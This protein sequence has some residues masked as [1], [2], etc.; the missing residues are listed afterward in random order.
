M[1]DCIVLT[2]ARYAAPRTVDWYVQQVLDEDQ[3]VV[4]A[5]RAQ[6]LS[7]ERRSWDDPTIDFSEVRAVIFRTTWDYFDRWPEFSAWLETV[8]NQTKLINAAELVHW[9]LDKRYLVE[10]AAKSI[11]VVPTVLVSKDDPRSLGELLASTGWE[12][13][14]AKPAISGAGRDTFRV[15]TPV[16]SAKAERWA[17][18]VQAEDMLLQPFLPS[19]LDHGETS[20]VVLDGEVTHA[21]RKVAAPGEFRV[22]DDHGGH[23]VPHEPDAAELALAKAA[24]A[25][26]E[27]RPLYAR[28][29]IARLADGNPAI[30][31]LELVEPELFFRFAPP[32]AAERLAKAVARYLN[33][34]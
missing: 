21:V 14:V 20:L 23:V 15:P 32:T 22:Q 3:A 12:E 8:Q 2:E 5:L 11:D 18:L 13:A 29:D 9:N 7:T 16:P 10:L 34:A 17:D 33:Q 4:D 28:V 6:G 31:E 26:V 19:I 30:M 25:A 27:P 1:L 24:V